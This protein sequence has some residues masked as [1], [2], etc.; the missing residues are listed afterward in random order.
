M[1]QISIEYIYHSSFAIS[2]DNKLLIFD[3]F[4]G[5]L[6]NLNIDKEIYFFASHSHEDHFNE[7][8]LN[9]ENS[10]NYN[11][12]LS[13]DIGK[14]ESVDKVISLGQTTSEIEKQ[15]RYH[16]KNIH[17][18]EANEILEHGGMNIRTFGST[19]KG[20]SFLVSIGDIGIFHAGDL[21]L[22]IWDSDT[23]DEKEEM[24]ADFLKE[25][26]RISKFNTTIAFFPLDPRMEE[27]Y[28]DGFNIFINQVQPR[29]IF[30]MHFR[31]NYS[32]NLKYLRDYS[33]HRDIFK[34]ILRKDQI[35]LINY[36]GS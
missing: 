21:N 4:E 18:M 23:E 29:L 12:I 2:I 35:F 25:I 8:I 26:D 10:S 24:R 28:A 33:Q 27:R 14:L 17:H 31:D 6:P 3:Y 11:Y 15:K 1:K 7:K 9:L 32:Y 19:D 16:G 22:W 34:P 36:S 20:V 13:S 5:E 30:P